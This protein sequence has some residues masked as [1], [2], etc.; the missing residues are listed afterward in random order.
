MNKLIIALVSIFLI[1]VL[2]SP[3]LLPPHIDNE[4]HEG[5]QGPWPPQVGKVYPDLILIDQTG[6]EFLLSDYK[7]YII[8][9]EPVG[10][11]CPACQA[12]SG[13]E[14]KGAFQ[15]NPVQ[16]GL[17]PFKELFP[18]Y[19]DGL[20]LP[21]PKIVF[22]QLLLYDMSL[23]PPAA[24]HAEIWAEHFGFK[25]E[26]NEIDAVSPY[27]LRG[28]ASYNLIPGFQLIDSNFILRSDST[29]HFPRDGLYWT[30]LPMVR[31]LLKE[32]TSQ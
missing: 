11:N 26:N 2:L 7:G 23:G 32:K 8:I 28:K 27:D 4:R 14:R 20:Q 17:P 16:K 19:T 1:A 21:H 31:E 13:A 5:I 24:K 6:Q 12:F 18:S 30:L 22:I 9:I 29:G 10:M 15:N 3:F 25:K